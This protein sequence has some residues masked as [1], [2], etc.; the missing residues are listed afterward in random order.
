MKQLPRRLMLLGIVCLMSLFVFPM[1]Q[2]ILYAPQYPDGVEMHIYI[3]KIGGSSPGTLQ[4][5]NILNHYVGMQYIEPDDIP[6]LQ[7]FPYIIGAMG[8][9]GLIALAIN[10]KWGYLSWTIVLVVLGILGM[11]D[12]YLWEYDYGHNLS[13][14]APIKIPGASFQPPLIG[15]KQIINFIADSWPHIGGIGFGLSM[16][17]GSAAWWSRKK[18]LSK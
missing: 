13:D 8:L 15:R 12:F 3:D 4:N 10:K 5:V 7:Y 14:T 6:E 16:F 17:F 1:W 2:I 9:L 18:Q 11:Y